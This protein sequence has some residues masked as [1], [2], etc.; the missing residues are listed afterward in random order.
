MVVIEV[1]NVVFHY[2]SVPALKGISMKLASGKLITILGPNGSG[3]TTLLKCL[4]RLLKPKAG[5][6]RFNG[7]DVWSI[8]TRLFARQVGYV[9]Q[10]HHP[11]Y[12]YRVID[13]VASGR[14]PYMDLFEM[15]SRSDYEAAL[16][17]LRLVGLEHLAERPYTELSGGELRLVLI[18]RALAQNPKVLLLD[19]PTAN[20]DF[21]NKI[22][23]MR[24]LKELARRG[25]LILVTEHDPNVAMMFSDEAIL[26][27]DGKI[28]AHGKPDEVINEDSMKALYSIDVYVISISSLS[29]NALKIVIPKLSLS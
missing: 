5:Y 14:T 12:P 16:Q 6:I 28:I 29:G 25:L 3:K 22:V 23:V 10:H 1:E 18:A 20:L 27:K 15:P 7:Q 24:T 8:N 11:V 4:C 17:A 9:P 13:V 19:E 26:M 2:D 21:K